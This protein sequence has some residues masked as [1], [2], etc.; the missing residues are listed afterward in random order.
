MSRLQKECFLVSAGM[1]VLLPVILVLGSALSPRSKP[2]DN[3]PVLD[4]IPLLTTDLEATGGGN[5]NVRTAPPQFNQ[6]LAPTQPAPQPERSPAPTPKVTKSVDD[7][8]PPKDSPEESFEP[9]NDS[10]KKLP[11]VPTTLTTRKNPNAPRIV[12]KKAA[13]D[14]VER[15]R[16]RQAT[17]LRKKLAEAVGSAAN[18]LRDHTSTTVKFTHGFAGNG[19]DG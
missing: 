16:E 8:D 19:T 5:R 4:I 7:P 18:D 6:P 17:E 15:E 2:D 12:A 14:S 10:R 3:M 9:R 11:N 1:H 13:D